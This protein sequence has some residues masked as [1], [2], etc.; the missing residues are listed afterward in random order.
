MIS[1]TADLWSEDEWGFTGKWVGGHL[2]SGIG[3]TGGSFYSVTICHTTT[4]TIP[5]PLLHKKQVKN[6]KRIWVWL[7]FMKLT[8]ILSQKALCKSP[9]IR[10]PL[11]KKVKILALCCQLNFYYGT[12]RPVKSNDFM[13]RKNPDPVETRPFP[14]S[15]PRN[16]D[17]HVLVFCVCCV[18]TLGTD[19]VA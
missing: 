15:N 4:S 18:Y 1:L 14:W 19:T 2:V 17:L 11:R 10:K 7:P 5:P 13:C 12:V 6:N 9:E 8:Q 3:T 16:S